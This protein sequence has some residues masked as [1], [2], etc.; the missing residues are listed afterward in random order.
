MSHPFGE[1]VSM[2]LRKKAGLSQKKLADG[3][4]QDP[5]VISD[6]CNGKRLKGRQARERVID[7]VCWLKQEGV[8]EYVDEVEAILAAAGLSGLSSTIEKEKGLLAILKIRDRKYDLDIPGLFIPKLRCRKVWGREVLVEEIINRLTDSKYAS[9]IELSSGP[10]YGKTEIACQVAHEVIATRTFKN[11]LWITA[12]QTDYSFD[13][14]NQVPVPEV[15]T[16]ARF[17][18]ELAAQLRCPTDQVLQAIKSAR[19]L[20]VLDNAETADL[21]AILPRLNRMLHPSHALLTSRQE[22]PM[23]Y[24]RLIKVPGLDKESSKS[25]LL[26]EAKQDNIQ[27]LIKASSEEFDNI[28]KLS[29]GAPLALHFI[30]S[31]VRYDHA[32]ETVLTSLTTANRQVENFYRFCL[33]IAWER[34]DGDAKSILRYMGHLANASVD[35][36]DLMQGIGI[37]LSRLKSALRD[38]QRWHLVDL[39]ETGSTQVRYDLHPWIRSSIRGGLVEVWSPSERDITRTFDKYKDQFGK[40]KLLQ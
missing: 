40:W 1:L 27:A 11:V 6:M 38:L 7:I 32:L 4:L 39:V 35:D 13:L 21:G 20:L 28:H 16:L 23:P 12:R 8:V 15:L 24:T 18:D 37:E 25:L 34:I 36:L 2:H 19:F 29:C 9:V 26:D 22:T 14:D 33:E 30:V 10:G 31:R 3:I 5:A 17:M